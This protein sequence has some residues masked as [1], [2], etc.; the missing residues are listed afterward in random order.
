LA[1]DLEGL[2]VEPYSSAF[3]AMR[4]TLGTEP[5]VA[6][7][8]AVLFAEVDRRPVDAGVAAVGDDGEGVLLLPAAFHIWP[9]V[10]IIAGMEASTM[11]SLGTC[12]LVMPLSELTIARR[13]RRVGGGD[14][15]LDRRPCSAGEPGDLLDEVAEAVVQVDAER[16]SVAACLAKRS[17][18]KAGRRGRR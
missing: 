9:E 13:G 6:G 14:V 3:C 7:R 5:M 12:R 4:P 2:V 15:G 10:R 1:G 17:L 16:A 11:T 8:G 18:K